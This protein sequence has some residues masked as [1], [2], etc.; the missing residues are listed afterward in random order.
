[1]ANTISSREAAIQR[2]IGL[3]QQVDVDG[4]TFPHVFRHEPV[5]I[6]EARCA[7]LVYRGDGES[8]GYPRMTFGHQMVALRFDIIVSWPWGSY[9]VGYLDDI[10]KELVDV[11][12][13]IQ[14]VINGD[15]TLDGNVS[16]VQ[17]AASDTGYMTQQT[18]NGAVYVGRWLQVPI[19]VVLLD[20]EVIAL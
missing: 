6:P 14:A 20:A 4:V 3:L 19:S 13:A 10:E 15:R 11:D 5:Y 1:M 8:E 9:D 17:T 7:A 12:R 16:D 18:D 2:I